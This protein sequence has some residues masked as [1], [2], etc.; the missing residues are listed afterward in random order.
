MY[1][2]LSKLLPT[3]V[4]L[5]DSS[6]GF[7]NVKPFQ[8]VSCSNMFGLLMDTVIDTIYAMVYEALSTLN[9]PNESVSFIEFADIDKKAIRT[10]KPEELVMALPK[11][12]VQA[13]ANMCKLLNLLKSLRKSMFKLIRSHYKAAPIASWKRGNTRSCPFLLSNVS[14]LCRLLPPLAN[15][16]VLQSLHIDVPVT[17]SS[18]QEWIHA[19]GVS[20]HTIA[21]DGLIMFRL[22]T[23]TIDNYMLCRSP[24]KFQD[25]ILTFV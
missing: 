12:K 6:K 13:N 11:A 23:E 5:G 2:L 19:D 14:S 1:F 3:N 24:I 16:Y 7:L 4:L 21:V 18:L 17:A 20:K 15:K 10:E 9:D 22:Y 8:R 25:K